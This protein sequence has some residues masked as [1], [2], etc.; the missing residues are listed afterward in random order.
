MDTDALPPFDSSAPVKRGEKRLS[1][2]RN[3]WNQDSR[4]GPPEDQACENAFLLP[5]GEGQ[6][7]GGRHSILSRSQLAG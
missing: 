3:Y 1:P 2:P 7:E 6:D 5:G 4:E